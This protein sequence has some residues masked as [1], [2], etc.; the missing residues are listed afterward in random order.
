MP[1]PA[2]ATPSSSHMAAFSFQVRERYLSVCTDVSKLQ[3]QH[4]G[5]PSW[6]LQFKKLSFSSLAV[7]SNLCV[8]LW[9]PF[10]NDAGW[11]VVDRGKEELYS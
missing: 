11:E 10:S 7:N 1:L 4:V 9:E 5:S 3:K 2:T 8:I 6:C